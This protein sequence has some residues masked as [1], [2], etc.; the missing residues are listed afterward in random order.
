MITTCRIWLSNTASSSRANGVPAIS[1]N[2]NGGKSETKPGLYRKPHQAL[3]A[4]S[5]RY[6]GSQPELPTSIL[7]QVSHAAD[8]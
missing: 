2:A 5:K 4:S 6:V 1:L 7:D 8:V 3:Q